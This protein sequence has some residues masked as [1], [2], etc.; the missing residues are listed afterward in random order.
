MPGVGA[1]RYP[2]AA[3]D[4]SVGS[5]LGYVVGDLVEQGEGALLLEY[6]NGDSCAD[7][8]K[9]MVHIHFTCGVGAGTVRERRGRGREKGEGERERERERERD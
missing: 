4:K 6:H 9:S 3:N 8:S 1:C 2:S 5:N 7:G